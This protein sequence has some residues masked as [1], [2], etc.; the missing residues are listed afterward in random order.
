MFGRS[1]NSFVHGRC[2]MF[3]P[4]AQ[5][6]AQVPT[7]QVAGFLS[8]AYPLERRSHLPLAR[9]TGIGGWRNSAP[10]VIHQSLSESRSRIERRLVAR[11][12]IM[13]VAMLCIAAIPV[14]GQAPTAASPSP[15]G[16][17]Q[18]PPGVSG[19]VSAAQLA[20]A[21]NPLADMNALNFQNYYAPTLY[22]LPNSNSNTLNLRPVVVSGRQIIRATLPIS[23]VPIG[24]GQYQSG[25][26]DL[27]IF[28]AIKLT[29]TDAKT[30][31]AVGPLLVAPSATDRTLGQGKW[32]AGVAAVAIHPEPGGSLLGFLATWQHSFA[33][34]S[35]RHG[36]QLVTFQPIG[37]LSIGK[38]YYFRSTAV[39]VF[40][41][42][43]GSYLIPLGIGVGKVFKV[44]NAVVNAFIEPQVTTYHNRSGL[45]SFQLFFG[46]NLQ[47]PKKPKS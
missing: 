7:W 41:I 45:P 14:I 22:G 9:A 42:A 24:G 40:D 26:G 19:G 28:A 44:Q 11:T 18:G 25:L 23:T 15:Q 33:G 47:F 16:E 31:L 8:L 17:T 38:G 29:S 39:W 43:N 46:L 13:T 10:R 20:N 32:Q 34:Q 35:D 27:S 3:K 6:P 2:R 5:V 1:S 21:N 36:A 37:T 30:D 12:F 4:N